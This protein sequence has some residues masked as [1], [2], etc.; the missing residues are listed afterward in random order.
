MSRRSI[1][2]VIFVLGTTLLSAMYYEFYFAVDRMARVA[3]IESG[4]TGYYPPES[5][6]WVAVRIALF[7]SVLMA[8]GIALLLLV[9]YAI[10][11]VVCDRQVQEAILEHEDLGTD[12]S[13]TKD[14]HWHSFSWSVSWQLPDGDKY[15]RSN[16]E[17]YFEDMRLVR[18]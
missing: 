9:L 6:F 1:L 17:D 8:V 4:D 2:A 10:S 12:Y 13:V 15:T 3:L 5:H 11:R 14:C 16:S 18:S 7:M